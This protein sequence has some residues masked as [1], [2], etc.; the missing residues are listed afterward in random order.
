MRLVAKAACASAS[1]ASRVTDHPT[2]AAAC[3]PACGRKLTLVPRRRPAY[4]GPTTD[5]RLMEGIM[6]GAVHQQVLSVATQGERT[7]L[8]GVRWQHWHRDFG[9]DRLRIH[10]VAPSV[11]RHRGRLRR[12]TRRRRRNALPRARSAEPKR[13]MA[14]SCAHWHSHNLTCARSVE[15][16]LTPGGA[17]IAAL[18]CN[19]ALIRHARDG[20]AEKVWEL[21]ESSQGRESPHHLA[22]AVHGDH[23][24][25]IDTRGQI[26]ADH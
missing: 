25:F 4:A 17:T 11:R 20:S 18:M 26:R 7:E 12:A 3:A 2:I 19:A 23:G 14:K 1:S 22:C 9:A 6:A 5:L 8:A 16:V 13:P 24:R 21:S 10:V 15:R